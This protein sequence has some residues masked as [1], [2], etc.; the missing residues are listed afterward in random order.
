[1]G[2][3]DVLGLSVADPDGSGEPETPPVLLHESALVMDAH[4]AFTDYLALR[5]TADDAALLDGQLGAAQEFMRAWRSEIGDQGSADN[6]DKMKLLAG[7]I[8]IERA[9]LDELLEHVG[10]MDSLIE[11]MD[12][13]RDASRRAALHKALQDAVQDLPA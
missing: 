12:A 13:E 1:M 3:L 2:L 9:A 10:D 8:E 5:D 6:R 7:K 4:S 11:A